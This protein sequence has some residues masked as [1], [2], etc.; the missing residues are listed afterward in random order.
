MPGSRRR[1]LIAAGACAL[2]LATTLAG[3]TAAGAEMRAK[4]SIIKGSVANPAQWPF[5]TAIL[6]KGRLHCGGSVIAST[7]ILTA[8][9][10]VLGFK[11]S[12]LTVAVSRPNLQ[13]EGVGEVIPVLGSTIHPDYAINQRHDIAVLTLARPTT[14]TPIA[15]PTID[16]AFAATTVGLQL[17]VAGYGA[18]SP[19]GF[20]LSAVLLQTIEQIRS[21]RRCRRPYREVFSGQAMICALGRRI[22]KFRFAPVH[23][24]SCSGDS[25]GPMV[26]DTPTGPKVV[27]TVSFGSSICGF[28]G[29]PTV[30]SRVSD[31]L[32]FIQSTL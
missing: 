16:E 9:H 21:P 22:K 3:S 4:S 6:R 19:F 14:A 15:L 25:G 5:A 2:A 1:G 27:G 26:A 18:R 30:Y 12:N 7:K 28:S 20:S 11:P 24:T 17:R 29:A 10:C 31:S 8:A 23:S 13:D 32:A